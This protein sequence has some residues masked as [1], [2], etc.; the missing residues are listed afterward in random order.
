[1]GEERYHQTR[2]YVAQYCA[3]QHPVDTEARRALWVELVE[4]LGIDGEPEPWRNVNITGG[5]PD[6]EGVLPASP[7]SRAFRA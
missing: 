2:L 5:T 7:P 1:M 6:G 4:M 3:E